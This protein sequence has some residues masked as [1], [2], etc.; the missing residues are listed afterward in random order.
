ML[1]VILPQL[2][3]SH[4]WWLWYLSPK[5]PVEYWLHVF[6]SFKCVLIIFNQY[7]SAL[8]S[9]IIKNVWMSI[10]LSPASPSTSATTPTTSPC[11]LIPV[12][13]TIRTAKWL[14]VTRTGEAGEVNRKKATFPFNVM[15][16]SRW[17]Y[18]CSYSHTVIMFICNVKWLFITCEHTTAHRANST[19]FFSAFNPLN[20]FSPFTKWSDRQPGT[21]R[22]QCVPHSRAPQWCH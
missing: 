4:H 8:H 3:C 20:Q 14:C 15:Q 2:S 18:A 10:S 13:S 7:V 16:T 22:E 19:K 11:T 6:Y 12:S 9:C 5:L 21:P 17:H 1:A